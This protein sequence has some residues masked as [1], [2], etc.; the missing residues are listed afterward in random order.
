M[1]LS[2]T[3]QLVR[4]SF[5]PRLLDGKALLGHPHADICIV[6]APWDATVLEILMQTRNSHRCRSVC[7]YVCTRV[8]TLEAMCPV[9]ELA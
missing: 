5:L 6:G 9:C 2:Q 8:C 3:C 7:S 4:V 1:G